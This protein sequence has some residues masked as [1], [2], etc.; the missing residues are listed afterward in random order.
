VFDIGHVASGW[1][2][3]RYDSRSLLG[4]YYALR[5]LSLFVLPGLIAATAHPSML[6]FVIFYGL[7]WVATVPPTIALCRKHFGA[8]GPIVFGWVFASHQVG[9]AIA[10]TGAGLV[11]DFGGDYNPAWITAGILCLFAAVMSVRISGTPRG[12]PAATLATA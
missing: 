12:T 8:D 11:R 1:L 3:D 10:A 5:G 4:G 6:I 2:S 7:D 9:A